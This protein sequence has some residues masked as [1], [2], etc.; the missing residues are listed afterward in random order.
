MLVRGI[1]ADTE[2]TWTTLFREQAKTY[3]EPRLV[4]FRGAVK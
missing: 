2:T 1:L 4:L 3:Q